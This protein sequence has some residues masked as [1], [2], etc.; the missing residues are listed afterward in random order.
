MGFDGLPDGW[1]VWNDEPEGR[2]ILA[3]RPDVFDT[4]RFPAP[5]LPTIF[6]T[7]GS[8][9]RRPGASQVPTDEWHVT[10]FLEPEVEAG[11]ETYDTRDAAVAGAISY[12]RRF[13]SGE[14]DYRGL[15][16]VPREEYFERLDELTGRP[17][18]E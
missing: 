9:R 12:A 7:N 6:V 10:L 18:D 13:A 3:Y 17:R 8:R 4:N 16:Q 1:T 15:Y 5:C 2:G 11:T 14:I